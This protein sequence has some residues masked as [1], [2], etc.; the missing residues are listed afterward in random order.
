MFD[1]PCRTRQDLEV[2]LWDPESALAEPGSTLPHHDCT[3]RCPSAPVHLRDPA[4]SCSARHDRQYLAVL[5][6]T[7]QYCQYSSGPSCTLQ[8]PAV[9]GR[10]L[11][12]PAQPCRTR[13]DP[14]GPGSTQQNPAGACSRGRLKCRSQCACG[15]GCS[16]RCCC[17]CCCRCGRRSQRGWLWLGGEKLSARPLTISFMYIQDSSGLLLHT[18]FYDIC[19]IVV[20][21]FGGV[22]EFGKLIEV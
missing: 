1:A 12:C 15:C 22:G 11:L 6:S 19:W 9:P 5:G 20:F 7:Q 8:N 18:Q 17:C 16:C 3:R 21:L 13:Q 14:T 4:G 10:A 2:P